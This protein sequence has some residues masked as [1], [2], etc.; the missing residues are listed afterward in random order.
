MS[1][2]AL[3]E[4]NYELIKA[5]IIN[6]ESSP[7]NAEHQEMLDRIMSVAKVL[8]KN[9]FKKHAVA[10]H[11][12]KYSHLSQRQAY[13]DVSMAMRLY[14][15]IHEFDWDFYR[16]WL[17]N[18][19]IRNIEKLGDMNTH[20]SR[21]VIAME[22]ANLIKT[23]GTKPEELE[24]PSRLEKQNYFILIQNNNQQ[25]KIDINELHTLPEAT[26]KEINK[27]IFAGAQINATDVDNLFKS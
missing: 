10:L 11:M 7:L 25:V 3:E 12:A 4:S 13:I 6:P 18:S 23:I 2:L 5:H 21:K 19:I 24:D 16:T 20:H 22:H 9:P 15:S 27:A 1:K 14:N 17:I 8:D 26:L